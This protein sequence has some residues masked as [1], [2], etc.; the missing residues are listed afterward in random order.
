MPVGD[1]SYICET[2]GLTE[3][4]DSLHWR[5]ARC[6][7][8]LRIDGQ[9]RLTAGDVDRNQPSLWRYAAAL[10]ADRA[11]LR[12]LGEGMTPLVDGT[13][14]G[15]AVRFKLD[16]LLPTGSFKDRGA[17]VLVAH[18]RWLGVRRVVVDSSGN[19]AAALAGYCAANDL[20]CVVFAPATTSAGKLV[21]ARAFGAAVHLIAGN[22]EDVARA[23]QESA[24]GDVEAFYASHNW[25]P[26]F[27]AGV[28]TWAFEVWEQ[29][30]QRLPALAVVPTG[31]GSA[32]VGGWHGF[33]AVGGA[34]P[35]LLCAQPAACAPI[36]AALRTGAEDIA[37]VSPG[38]T[39]AEGTRIGAPARGRQILAALRES[40]GWVEAVEER[41]IVDALHE[42]WGQGFYVEPT[43]AVGAAPRRAALPRGH[44]LPNGDVVVLLTG[45]GL[46][47]TDALGKL[48]D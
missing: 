8:A 38:E 35:V 43:A 26:V 3:P 46:K 24:A 37:P 9:S 23:A 19:A 27:V 1:W 47:A 17:A 31:G 12:S 20:E 13:I 10:P 33:A 4:P 21:Q 29:L 6:G 14:G 2:C 5:C 32:L 25:H 48:L 15:R 45:S 22:R 16:A 44:P 36:A 28:Q 11:H 40:R 18:L 30:G 41:Q 39:I 7:S 34:P 42:L